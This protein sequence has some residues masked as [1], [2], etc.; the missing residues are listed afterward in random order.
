MKRLVVFIVA[1]T[2]CEVVVSQVPQGFNYQAL[3]RNASGTA[4]PNN[5]TGFRFS[6]LEGSATGTLVYSETFDLNTDAQGVVS[7]VI[8]SGTVVS[9]SFSNIDWSAGPYYLKVQTDPT[10]GTGYTL[11]ETKSLQWVPYSHFANKAGAMDKGKIEVVGDASQ[12]DE[13]ALFEVKRNDGQ[14]VFA[15]YPDGVR[16]YVMDESSKGSKGGFAVGGFDPSKGITDEYLRV[17]PDSVRIYISPS[18]TKASKGGFAV[19]GYDPVKGLTGDYFNVSTNAT[20]IIDPSQN[21]VLWYPLKNAFLTGR[22]LVQKSDSVGENSF[23]TGYESKAIGQYSQAMGYQ[24][25]ARGTYS[26]SI[27]YQSVANKDNSF[28]FGQWAQARNSESYAFGRGAIAEGF[29]SFAFGSAG[30]DSLGATTGVAYAKGA[31]SF[32]LGMGSQA[33]GD[34]SFAIGIADTAS[35]GNS[36][37]FGLET[38]SPGWGAISMGRSTRASG[39]F[40]TSMGWY[41]KASGIFSTATGNNTL[42]SGENSFAGGAGS[43]SK[44]LHSFSFGLSTIT[45]GESSV[46]LGNQTKADGFGSM[47]GG[48]ESTASNYNAFAFGYRTQA[49][50]YQSVAMGTGTRATNYHSFAMGLNS[51][52]NGQASVAFGWDTRANSFAALVVGRYND[53]TN[54]TNTTWIESTDPAFVIGNGDSHTNRRNAFTVLQNSNVGINMVNPQQK[55]DIAGGNGRVESGYNW[56]TNSDIRFKKNVVTLDN[57]LEK[58]MAMRGV[59]FDLVNA[60]LENGILGKNIGFIA[61]ELEKVIPEVVVTGSDG[62]KSVAYDK[63]TA[64]LTEA[65]KEQQEIIENQQQQIDELKTLVYK[66]AEK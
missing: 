18:S 62:F 41:T 42:A 66:L 56:L 20:D 51:H 55:L 65:I 46:A 49:T 6:I 1:L 17:S 40:S 37:S 29:S 48:S 25:I 53:T 36:F 9:G 50:G 4:L 33:L 59:S 38:S 39:V 57:S 22:V 61:Q 58:V 13:E 44:G 16:I 27:G 30:I 52:A 26:T 8:G 21:R 34:G 7:L 15:V 11:T 32:A 19:G 43:K 5:N 45:N 63:I 23:A 64:V 3:V 24:A 12:N 2:I 10:G 54:M 47:A 31:Y 14:T 35:G 60:T 28:A